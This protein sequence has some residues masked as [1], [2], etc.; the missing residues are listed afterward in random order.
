MSG[1]TPEQLHDIGMAIAQAEAAISAEPEAFHY[2]DDHAQVVGDVIVMALAQKGFV[3]T[4]DAIA[5]AV[6]V[7]ELEDEAPGDPKLLS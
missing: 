3:V 4:A 7:S 2:I 5:A 6:I 1:F